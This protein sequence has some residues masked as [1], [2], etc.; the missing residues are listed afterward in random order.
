MNDYDDRSTMSN[1]LY[2]DAA[3]AIEQCLAGKGTAKSTSLHQ[4]VKNKRATYA[5]VC[6]TLKC[7][8]HLA[9]A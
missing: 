4:R 3:S 8:M 5:I 9:V 2:M 7:A 1:T 6:E